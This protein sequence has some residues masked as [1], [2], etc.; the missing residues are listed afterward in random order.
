MTTISRI[1]LRSAASAL[2]LGVGLASGAAFASGPVTVTPPEVYVT[3]APA[4]VRD[5]G[6]FYGGL[7]YSS[8]SGE[9]NENIPGGIFPP[10]NGDNGAGAFIGYNVQRGNFVF[11]GE[12]SYISFDTAYV[13]FPTSFQQNATE[14]RARAG[15]AMNNVLFY[16]F[17]GAAQS[18]VNDGGTI[19]DQT[20]VSYGIGGQFM[21]RGGAFVGLELA[22]R[23]VSGTNGGNTLG[24]FIDTVS[25]RLGYQF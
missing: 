12:L 9:I 14:L 22:R 16:G 15:Y 18:R 8:I 2:A 7:S 13:G 6:G 10:L 4:P 24:S 5:W 25:L 3:P 23:D 17:V 21:V 20:G 19:F 11:G 1:A